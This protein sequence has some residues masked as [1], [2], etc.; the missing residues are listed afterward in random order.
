[1]N[2]VLLCAV[3]AILTT[4]LPAA[5]L[6]DAATLELPPEGTLIDICGELQELKAPPLTLT[7]KGAATMEG[8]RLIIDVLTTPGAGTFYFFTSRF[9]SNGVT[10]RR[11]NREVQRAVYAI[12]GLNADAVDT[13]VFPENWLNVRPGATQEA[14]LF[15]VSFRLENAPVDAGAPVPW[16]AAAFDSSCGSVIMPDSGARAGF[17]A[18]IAGKDVVGDNVVIR[19]KTAAQMAIGYG[20]TYTLTLS[21]DAT[22]LGAGAVYI[23][24]TRTEA[25]TDAIVGDHA[26]PDGILGSAD[27]HNDD[28]RIVD[29]IFET[30]AEGNN[31]RLMLVT[32]Q[33]IVVGATSELVVC[34]PRVRLPCDGAP[35]DLVAAT[36]MPAGFPLAFYPFLVQAATYSGYIT[37]LA[38]TDAVSLAAP[39]QPPRINGCAAPAGGAAG[40]LALGE[41][42]PRA[43]TTATRLR[44][45]VSSELE[46]GTVLQFASQ[47]TTLEGATLTQVALEDRAA[48]Y[49]LDTPGQ[50]HLNDTYTLAGNWLVVAPTA[51]Q[52]DTDVAV[53]LTLDGDFVP[54]GCGLAWQGVVARIAND[55]PPTHTPTNTPT[56]TQT[57]TDTPTDAPTD[58]PTDTPTDAPTDTPTAAAT[59]TPT[60]TMGLADG[61]PGGQPTSPPPSNPLAYDLN[62]DGA[63]DYADVF[64][65]A[66]QM[67][68]TRVLRSDFNKDGVIDGRDV[69]ALLSIWGQRR[70]V[71]LLSNS[72]FVAA[73]RR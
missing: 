24:D 49:R 39:A 63:I 37:P 23:R 10:L 22:W 28:V 26:G 50:D 45:R 5:E 32:P 70:E 66:R 68:E 53:E 3:L 15:R 35:I 40:Q 19:F 65:F 2:K 44:L 41:G 51:T 33:P 14:A 42:S 18:P 11:T 69:L 8:A 54:S 72:V 43:L 36:N 57:P 64:V 13:V 62:G 20:V 27:D 59:A 1:M 58:T 55:C 61:T 73:I 60:P 6:G 25:L 30:T 52:T 34:A 7:E 4:T 12:E 16:T 71:D 17:D 31:L 21:G 47:I 67:E 38:L 29:S 56:P 46:A 9:T 48:V